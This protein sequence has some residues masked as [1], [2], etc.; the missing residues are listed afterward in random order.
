[1]A[2][3]SKERIAAI[4]KGGKG[5]VY[6]VSTNGVTGAREEISTDIKEYMDMVS[7]YTDM[8]RH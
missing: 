8:Q 1:M 6:C 3:T 2:P 4:T 5:F 7:N